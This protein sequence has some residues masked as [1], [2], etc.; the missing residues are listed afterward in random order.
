[1]E[2]ALAVVVLGAAAAAALW[3]AAF[4]VAAAV[5]GAAPVAFGAAVAGPAVEPEAAVA[6]GD[7]AAVQPELALVAEPAVAVVEAAAGEAVPVVGVAK[8]ALAVDSEAVAGQAEE[9]FESVQPP[10]L[11]G[12][13]SVGG[14]ADASSVQ[15][16]SSFEAVAGPASCSEAA[17]VGQRIGPAW[18]DL[19]ASF[20]DQAWR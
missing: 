10:E 9:P 5:L 16:A 12:Q 1:M 2:L 8:E 13:Q 3:M 15:I 17:A 4:G 18:Q 6:L 11:L 20:L 19:W 14:K 7:L